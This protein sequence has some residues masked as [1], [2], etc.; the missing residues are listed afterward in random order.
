[1]NKKV[2]YWMNK[3]HLHEHLKVTITQRTADEI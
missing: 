2:T 1:M 3:L